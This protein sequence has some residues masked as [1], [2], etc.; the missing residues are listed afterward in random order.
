MSDIEDNNNQSI[1]E[2]Q[3]IDKQSIDNNLSLPH[4]P[5][6]RKEMIDNLTSQLDPEDLQP[7][8]DKIKFENDLNDEITLFYVKPNKITDRDWT[9]PD[10]LSNLVNSNF[11]EII[12]TTPGKY[13]ETIGTYLN[14]EKYDYPDV[15]VSI[16]HEEENYMYELLYINTTP[17]YHTE[18]QENQFALMLQNNGDTKIYGTMLLMKSYLPINSY[19]MKIDTIK[20]KDIIRMLKNRANTSVVIYED[21]EYRQERVFG[22]MDLFANMYFKDDYY[23]KYEI[24]FLKHNLNIW[25]VKDEYCDKPFPKLLN[26]NIDKCIIFTLINDNYRGNLY[27]DEFN[28]IKYL[29][30]KMKTFKPDVKYLTD[31]KDELGRDIIKNKYRVLHMTYQDYK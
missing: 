15:K 27:L 28:K 11:C 7:D 14:I 10:Y 17:K 2:Q 4:N 20:K 16:I 9:E 31:E 13:I 30:N 3:T 23:E 26:K 6:E 1:D 22:P 19:S 25:Y 8:N 24:P 29:S 21:D 12:K 5:D 18:D